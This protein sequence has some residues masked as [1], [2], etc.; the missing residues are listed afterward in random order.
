LCFP[1]SRI[2]TSVSPQRDGDRGDGRRDQRGAHRSHQAAVAACGADGSPDAD[3]LVPRL[4]TSVTDA[5]ASVFGEQS[6]PG[7]TVELIA[8]PAG[9]TG[10]G[11]LLAE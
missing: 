3:E 2:T 9:R 6:R 7:I 1:C 10:V 11:G 4:I 5:V 8:T